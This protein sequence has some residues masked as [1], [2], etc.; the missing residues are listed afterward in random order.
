MSDPIL[1]AIAA[2][3]AGK[4]ASTLYELVKRRFSGDKAAADTLEAAQGS[5]PDSAEVHALA[6]KLSEAEDSDNAFATSLRTTWKS[7]QENVSG[8]QSG[9]SGGVANQMLGGSANTLIQMR[10]HNGD[11]NIGVPPSK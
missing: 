3:I 7:T 11:L 6:G 4:T 10:D 1:V 9:T 8:S 5:E 2:A